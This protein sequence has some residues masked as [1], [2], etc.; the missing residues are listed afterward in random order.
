MDDAILLVPDFHNLGCTRVFESVIEYSFD[1]LS[2]R[3]RCQM[4]DSLV[5]G[6]SHLEEIRRSRILAARRSAVR[7][8]VRCRVMSRRWWDSRRDDDRYKSKA[9]ALFPDPGGRF[10]LGK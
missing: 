9:G 4:V 8:A 1:K 2:P 5:R 6:Y 7:T 3:E 10:G